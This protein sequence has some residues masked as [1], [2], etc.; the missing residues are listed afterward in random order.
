MTKEQAEM[1]LRAQEEEEGRLRAEKR[2]GRKGGRP[3]V[4]RDW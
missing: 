3:P 4:T 1:L 2:K